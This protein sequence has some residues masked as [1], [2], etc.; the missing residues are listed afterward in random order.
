M[1]FTSAHGAVIT[2]QLDNV[3]FDDDGA[4]SGTFDF[5]ADADGGNGE[6]SNINITTFLGSAFAGSSYYV[7]SG[8]GLKP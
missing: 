7:L 3:S 2:W 1:L 5:D 6:I 4:A 8:G